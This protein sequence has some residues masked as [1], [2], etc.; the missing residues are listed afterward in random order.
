M[1]LASDGMVW[2]N[3][4]VAVG[5]E[6]E[7]NGGAESFIVEECNEIVDDEI[8]AIRAQRLVV[9]IERDFSLFGIGN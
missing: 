8:G 9:E 3:L 7:I 4:G 2:P 6:L 5:D 1:N